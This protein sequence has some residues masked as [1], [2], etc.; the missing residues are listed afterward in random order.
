MNLLS[1]LKIYQRNVRIS[2][3]FMFFSLILCL[4]IMYYVIIGDYKYCLLMFIV[5]IWIYDITLTLINYNNSLLLLKYLDR[6]LAIDCSKSR[7]YW[8]DRVCMFVDYSGEI[9]FNIDTFKEVCYDND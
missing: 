4:A 3:I 6:G 9:F 1:N 7:L 5:L 2:L 8:G